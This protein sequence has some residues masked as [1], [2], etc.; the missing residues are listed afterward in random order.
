MPRPWSMRFVESLPE[1]NYF[2]PAGIRLTELAEVVL[3]VEEFEALRL[4]DL[5]ELDQSDACEKMG[6]SQPT[7]HRM[8]LSARKKT[9]DALVNGKA[10][11][12]EGGNYE[13]GR[14]RGLG[15]GRG[16]GRRRGMV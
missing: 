8:L 5:D 2:K 16:F 14:P 12:I 6:V 3:S 13:V 7:F 1:V 9:A 10:I 4:A 15:R 11:K